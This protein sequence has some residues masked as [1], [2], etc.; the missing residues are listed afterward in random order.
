[1][2]TS[3]ASVSSRERYAA[4]WR[5][6]TISRSRFGPRSC[7]TVR[8]K[9]SATVATTCSGSRMRFGF[10]YTA[11]FKTRAASSIVTGI[12]LS[13][14]TATRRVRAPS[15]SRTLLC[16]RRATCSTTSFATMT[17]LSSALARKIAMRVSR[18]GDEMSAMRPHSNR[19]RRRSSSNEISFGVR[20]D[21]NTICF[22]AE[23]SALN[24]WKNS[25]CVR[26]LSARN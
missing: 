21:V 12:P 5:G 26:S 24:V 13:R 3:E 16:T 20:S 17:P 23:C 8:L 11:S 4:I 1:M 7:S 18:S 9:C 2:R 10:G 19:E 14:P 22:P 15:S 6:V 25:S